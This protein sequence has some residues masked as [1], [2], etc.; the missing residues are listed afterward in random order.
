MVLL[1]SAAGLFLIQ[2]LSPAPRVVVYAGE[3]AAGQELNAED[4][5]T[6]RAPGG[7]LLDGTFSLPEDLVGKQLVVGRP[8]GAV[9]Y[10]ADVMGGGIVVDGAIEN[11]IAVP[12]DPLYSDLISTGNTVNIFATDEFNQVT[13]VAQNALVV[14]VEGD[15]AL[16]QVPLE[17]VADL[18]SA[19]TTKVISLS[20]NYS[21]Q[22]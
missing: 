17:Q 10:A 19:L 3:L 20:L 1:M 12:L 9:A 6:V 11:A 13:Q 15:R 16:V 14:R 22:K 21:N 2:V 4:L 7:L 5:R 18:T 8:A